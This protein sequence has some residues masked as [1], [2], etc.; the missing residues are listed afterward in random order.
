MS[1]T[2][3][4]PQQKLNQENTEKN[5]RQQPHY[6]QYQIQPVEFIARNNLSFLQ[7]NVI[8][9][10]LRYNLKNGLEDLNKARHY[11]DMLISKE[12]GNFKI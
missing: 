5:I 6:T 12:E 3:K 9:Y 7:G 2:P 4:K 10:L 1:T 11:L 8:K